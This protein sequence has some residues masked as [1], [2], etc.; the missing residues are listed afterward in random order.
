[1]KSALAA[2]VLLSPF[3]LSGEPVDKAQLEKMKAALENPATGLQV[4]S[5][6][7][8]EVPGMFEVQFTNGPLVYATADGSYF[9]VGDLYSVGPDGFVNLAEQRRDAERAQ[10]LA[11]VEEKDM[12]IF[13]PEGETRAHISVFTDVT[14]FYC[15]KLHQ[16]VPE[17]NKRG[18]EVRYLAYPRAGA[19]SDGFRKLATAWCADDRQET[20]TRLKAK[21]SVDEKVCEE[22]PVAEQYQLGAQM[23]VRGTP[24]IVTQD[25]R[26]IPGYQSA[27]QLLVSLGLN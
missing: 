14:C 4:D 19:D 23:G 1:M 27:D 17:L 6:Q 21:K 8:S 7:T 12:I 9:I 13:S 3:A 24:A 25:G 2:L 26:L 10:L 22:N 16:E 11:A 5:A 15:Q 20:L 18:I